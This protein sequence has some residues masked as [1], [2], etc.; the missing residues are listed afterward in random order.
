MLRPFKNEL[1][2]YRTKGLSG[3]FMSKHAN[4]KSTLSKSVG[5]AVG[6]GI[7][8]TLGLEI[9]TNGDFDDG[10]TG[11]TGL[12]VIDGVARTLDT[13]G[14]QV[15]STE[16]GTEY[17]VTFL[18]DAKGAS[19]QLQIQNGNIT[20]SPVIGEVNPAGNGVMKPCST[21]FT[22]L[23]LESIIILSNGSNTA[24]WDDISVREILQ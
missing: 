18:C 16:I 7:V 23:G 4:H 19:P 1:M 14:Y 15:V 6:L 3:P 12:D 10:T 9:V 24:L 11:W 8:P 22:A 20:G 13:T 17:K 21:T 2:M 5:T